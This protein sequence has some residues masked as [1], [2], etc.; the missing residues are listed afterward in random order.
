MR[1][2]ASNRLEGRLPRARSRPSSSRR[3][4]SPRASPKR[5]SSS[6]R[7]RRASASR[8][9]R[10]RP[11]LKAGG[12]RCAPTRRGSGWR[13][14]ATLRCS[15]SAYTRA[16]ATTALLRAVPT[17]DARAARVG[18]WTACLMCYGQTTEA[19]ARARRRREAG[20]QRGVSRAL[21][22]SSAAATA[23]AAEGA[24]VS[25]SLPMEVI[26]ES[27]SS[28]CAST[29]RAARTSTRRGSWRELRDLDHARRGARGSAP[30]GADTAEPND[31]PSSRS[32]H[33]T[34]L[35]RDAARYRRGGRRATTVDLVDLAQFGRSDPA[36]KGVERQGATTV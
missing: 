36:W 5:A 10:L 3:T 33:P 8:C 15:S 9:T 20:A 25:I 26:H 19:F 14:S 27:G 13:A 16:A 35:S 31:C 21:S 11:L 17:S 18:G 32:P 4:T 7:R 24:D 29:R 23:T 2:L 34:L 1:E 28:R 12:G 30:R 22:S 6:A